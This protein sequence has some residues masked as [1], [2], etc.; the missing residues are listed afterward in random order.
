MKHIIP[1][2]YFFAFGGAL[3]TLEEPKAIV[4]EKDYQP[5]LETLCNTDYLSDERSKK[6]AEISFWKKKLTQNSGGYLF[7]EKLG[8]AYTELFELTFNLH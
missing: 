2:L 7:H 8:R 4:S 6:R 3:I 5:I 1:I